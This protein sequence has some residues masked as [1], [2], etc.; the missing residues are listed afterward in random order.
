M[1][2]MNNL[3][4]MKMTILTLRL[5]ENCMRSFLTKGKEKFISHLFTLKT[6]NVNAFNFL[7][8]ETSG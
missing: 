2:K 3:L 7:K 8:E 4:Q 1:H 5:M 6:K